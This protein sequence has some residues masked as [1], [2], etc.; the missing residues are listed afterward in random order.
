MQI[1]R[2]TES[3][4]SFFK[5]KSEDFRK[6]S[7]RKYLQL[8]FACVVRNT[9]R[10]NDQYKERID[11]ERRGDEKN[12]NVVPNDSTSYREIETA[13]EFLTLKKKEET[14]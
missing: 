11:D 3:A 8:F 14:L 1:K 9:K 10:V 2:N 13:G 5:T 6:T 12:Q 7:K 4:S